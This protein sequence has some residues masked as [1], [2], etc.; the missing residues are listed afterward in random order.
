MPKALLQCFLQPRNLVGLR[1]FRTLY[2]IELNLIAL[3]QTLIA[4]QLDGAVVHE[5]IG[6]AIPAE[7]S[8]ALRI[9]EPFNG[10]FVL[11]QFAL[12]QA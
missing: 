3:L 1:S 6:S 10:A 4:F 5:N 12:L 9:V 2:D 7:K 11:C 8:I